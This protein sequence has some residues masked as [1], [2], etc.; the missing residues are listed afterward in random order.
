MELACGENSGGDDPDKGDDV[1]AAHW[2]LDIKDACEFE[3]CHS[4]A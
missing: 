1:L 3:S 4:A 2:G